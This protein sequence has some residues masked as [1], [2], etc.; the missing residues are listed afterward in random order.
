MTSITS[1]S[2]NVKWNQV[3]EDSQ[4]G[5]IT[6]Y[7]LKW[8]RKGEMSTKRVS[9]PARTYELSPLDEFSEYNMSIRAKTSAGNGP[10][11]DWISNRTDSARMK[12]F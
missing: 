4:H 12:F 2:L 6:G 10:W 7:D 3:P 8:G 5:V 9:T 11:S 1:T